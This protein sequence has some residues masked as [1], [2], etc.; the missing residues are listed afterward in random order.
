MRQRTSV[1]AAAVV[2]IGGALALP[3]APATAQTPADPGTKIEVD[4]SAEPA[5]KPAQPRA[6]KHRRAGRA[7]R[8]RHS[9]YRTS[10]YYA[11][12]YNRGRSLGFRRAYLGA[13]QGGPTYSAAY[14]GYPGY[15]GHPYDAAYN[16][17]GLIRDLPYRYRVRLLAGVPR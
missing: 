2:L 5:A 14:F 1:S 13:Y 7:V 16:G 17:T 3:L 9:Y 12:G 6:R 15:D 8:V 10:H 4:G 11:L